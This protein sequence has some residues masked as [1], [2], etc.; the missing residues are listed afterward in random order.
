V[1]SCSGRPFQEIHFLGLF[2]PFLLSARYCED[3]VDWGG[4]HMDFVCLTIG[5]VF[6]LLSGWLISALDQL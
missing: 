2:T 1:N 6:F 5:A 3:R 4:I